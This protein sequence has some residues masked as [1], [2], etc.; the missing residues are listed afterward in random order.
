MMYGN[1]MG[2]WWWIMVVGMVAFW[3][4]VAWAIVMSVRWLTRQN[5][6]G[7]G[8]RTL[9]DERFARGEI[10]EDEYRQRRQVLGS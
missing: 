3:A 9:L 7:R 6:S 10:G 4:I 1:D 8:A 2:G 5:G